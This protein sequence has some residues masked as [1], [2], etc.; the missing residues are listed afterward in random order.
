MHVE[1]QRRFIVFILDRSRNYAYKLPI[2]F[3][4]RVSFQSDIERVNRWI[5]LHA[6][7]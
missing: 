3:V 5:L 6:E 2:N 4:E 1:T 7:G